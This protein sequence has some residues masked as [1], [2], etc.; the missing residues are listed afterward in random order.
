SEHVGEMLVIVL[1]RKVISAPRIDEPIT[2]GSGIIRGN[3]NAETATN[4]AVLLRAGALPA[5]LGVLEQRTV[6]PGLGQDSIRAGILACAVGAVLVMGLMVATYGLFGMFANIALI[7]NVIMI[8][9]VMSLLQ[10]TLTLPGIAGIVLTM[11]MA[12]DANVLIYERIR[13]ELAAGRTPLSAVEAGFARA[14][15]AIVD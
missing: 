10:A 4:L 3:F 7:F 14:F 15:T 1:D 8:L 2:G 12:V 6:G 5:P 13:E 9:A 11:G